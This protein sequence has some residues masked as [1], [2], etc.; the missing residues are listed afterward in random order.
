MI[1]EKLKAKMMIDCERIVREHCEGRGRGVG[2]CIQQGERAILQFKSPTRA[3]HQC[4]E[5]TK[6]AY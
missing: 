5:E 6:H 2:G 4:F 3:S 1:E